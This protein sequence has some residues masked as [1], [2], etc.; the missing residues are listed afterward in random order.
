MRK[1]GL[2]TRVM[3]SRQMM[4]LI[5]YLQTRGYRGVRLDQAQEDPLEQ[6]DQG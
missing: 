5:Y 4:S 1:L 2:R 6:R 3:N